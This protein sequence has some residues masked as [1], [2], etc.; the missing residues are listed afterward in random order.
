MAS[1]FSLTVSFS[2]MRANALVSNSAGV[3]QCQS[4]KRQDGWFAGP[5]RTVQRAPRRESSTSNS[6]AQAREGIVPSPGRLAAPACLHQRFHDSAMIISQGHAKTVVL[7]TPHLQ[8]S[9]TFWFARTSGG[10][11]DQPVTM[12]AVEHDASVI[13][14]EEVRLKVFISY[15]RRDMVFADRLVAALEARGFDVLID[16]R[17]LP[18]LEDW[19]RE[20]GGF[21]R[22]SDTVVFIVSRHSISSNRLLKNDFD[23]SLLSL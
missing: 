20:L 2:A 10:A 17:N 16:R 23:L 15:S 12:A 14:R 1:D 4:L 9:Q 18:A 19:E 6:C 3:D 8:N 22:Q 7:I 21:I 5:L 11:M 13:N